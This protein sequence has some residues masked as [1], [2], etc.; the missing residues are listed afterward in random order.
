M[1]RQPC[2]RCE[3]LSKLYRQGE[4]TIFAVQNCNL[5]VYPGDFGAVIGKSGSGKSTLLNLIAGYTRPSQGTVYLGQKEICQMNDAQL[6]EVRRSGIGFVF[7]AYHLLPILTARENILFA[8]KDPARVSRTYFGELCRLLDIADRLDHLPSALS[9]G[10]QQRVAIARALINEPQ[11]L[12]ADEPTGNLDKESAEALI[13]YLKKI[14]RELGATLL[15]ATH[16]ADLAA[17]A[18]RVFEIKDGSV[19]EK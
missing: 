14:H 9:G 5:K 13:E 15:I 18:E 10:Q 17:A 7:Q 2:I 3:S 8:C 16:D 12:L 6:A 19:R 1:D 11:I 4:K